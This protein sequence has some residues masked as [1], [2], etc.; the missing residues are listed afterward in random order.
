MRFNSKEKIYL[1]GIVCFGILEA[2]FIVGQMYS[3]SLI[4][5]AVF[6]QQVSVA[7]LGKSFVQLFFLMT[8]VVLSGSMGRSLANKLAFAVKDNT[9]GLLL[10]K[11]D[12]LGGAYGSGVDSSKSLLFLTEGLERL[13]IFFA[14]FLPQVIK[15]ACI[16]ILFLCFVFPIDWVSGLLLLVTIPIIIIFMMLIGSFSKRAAEKQ[17]QVLQTI[18]GF[19]HDAMVYLPWLKIW[20]Q[21][22]S[23]SQKVEKMA[24]DFRLHTLKVMQIAF[25]SAFVLEL[26]TM[27]GVALVAVTLGVRLVEGMVEFPLALFVILLAPEFYVP[28]RNLGSK[29]HDSINAVA[30]LRDIVEF[31]NQD[32]PQRGSKEMLLSAAPNI[33]LDKVNYSYLRSG[34]TLQ[35]IN[36]KL[37]AAQ[38]T[39][40]FGQSGCGKSTL[41]ALAGGMRLAD[42]GSV[43]WNE[44]EVKDLSLATVRSQVGYLG[45]DVYIFSASVYENICLGDAA[46]S[47][48]QVHQACIAVGFAKI[49]EEWPEGYETLLGENGRALSGGQKRMIGIV[50]ILVRDRKF[51]ICDEP[52]AGLDYANEKIVTKALKNLFV[53]RT[54]L[55]VSHREEI[56][57]LADKVYFME[58]GILQAKM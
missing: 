2:L 45:Q 3:I 26:F 49:I 11:M 19:L 53:G 8:A 6:I 7:A 12:R 47:K 58:N 43:K 1:L 36:L 48:E 40:I 33:S 16:P 32:E 31:L 30:S 39:V 21:G 29:Y 44:H 9:A 17:W 41:L 34:F 52:L 24:D 20:G 50:R 18:S 4:A 10:E 55:V 25:L 57:H 46:I 35:N 13:E 28:L 22:E 56:I 54:V 42:S 27:L 15:T 14:Q 38:T 37:P 51:V 5:T 23:S